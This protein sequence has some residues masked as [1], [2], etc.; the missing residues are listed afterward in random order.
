[1]GELPKGG[2]AQGSLMGPGGLGKLEGGV[3]VYLSWV[4]PEWEG[5][6]L[7]R[8]LRGP[9]SL[10]SRPPH[11]PPTPPASKLLRVLQ[12]TLLVPSPGASRSP[13]SA[14]WAVSTAGLELLQGPIHLDPAS[15]T[16]VSVGA[17]GGRG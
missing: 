16:L 10:P 12:A 1:M 15:Y 7:L 17:F 11:L 14:T 4:G 2:G 6:S 3:R 9:H 5:S 8:S 13:S